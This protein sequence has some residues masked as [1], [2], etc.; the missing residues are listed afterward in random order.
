MEDLLMKNTTLVEVHELKFNYSSKMVLHGVNLT[1]P[2]GEIIGL[3]GENG[4]GFITTYCCA[5]S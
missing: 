1:V 2:T 5:I 3:I 4:A